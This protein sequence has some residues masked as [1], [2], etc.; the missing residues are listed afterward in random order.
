MALLELG[1]PIG[2]V[3]YFSVD[4]DAYDFE[5]TDSILPY[6]AEVKSVSN[7]QEMP[8]EQLSKIRCL[9]IKKHL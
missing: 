3:I 5:V 6:L 2:A 4:D 1:F 9:W 8:M 7:R